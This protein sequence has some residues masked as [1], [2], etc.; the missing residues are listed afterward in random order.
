VVDEGSVVAGFVSWL[1]AERDRA[2]GVGFL[3]AGAISLAVGYAGVA[4]AAYVPQALSFIASG[5]FF[6]LLLVAVGATLLITAALHDEWRKL[7]RIEK[8][9]DRLAQ[10]LGGID[11]TT[12]DLT[13]GDHPSAGSTT[14]DSGGNGLAAG[15]AVTPAA[16]QR[17]VLATALETSRRGGAGGA[18]LAGPSGGAAVAAAPGSRPALLAAVAGL[19]VSTGLVGGGW[20][21]TAS[22]VNDDTAY[23]TILLGITGIALAGVVSAG[24]TLHLRRVA[25][26]RQARLLEPFGPYLPSLTAAGSGAGSRVAV[27]DGLSRYHQPGC[28]ALRGLAFRLV[29]PAEATGS[30]LASCRLC[31][32]APGA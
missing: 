22:A 26:A 2:A 19:V 29:T 28:A 10:T 12:G 3:V 14:P 1:R 32:P 11:L 30:G 31:E 9:I 13:A 16:R 15:P 17:A 21:A 25:R 8:S 18:G 5:G 27:V 4:D 6:G 7:D 24:W 23:A 20:T